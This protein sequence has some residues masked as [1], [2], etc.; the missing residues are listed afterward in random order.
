MQSSCHRQGFAVEPLGIKHQAIT[1]GGRYHLLDAHHLCH[2]SPTAP[3]TWTPA[4]NKH[5]ATN[6]HGNQQARGN[7]QAQ[8]CGCLHASSCRR[9]HAVTTHA[10]HKTCMQCTCKKLQSLQNTV[11]RGQSAAQP[12][13]VCEHWPGHPLAPGLCSHL[14]P[15]ALINFN[16]SRCLASRQSQNVDWLPCLHGKP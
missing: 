15:S 7:K 4:T 12:A 8:Q 13:S 14:L 16:T 3:C 2:Q 9:Q 1:L 5:R 11:W 10:L 6:K